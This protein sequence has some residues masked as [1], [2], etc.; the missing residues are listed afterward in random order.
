MPG[1]I[2]RYQVRDKI[3]IGRYCGPRS[4]RYSYEGLI[5]KRRYAHDRGSNSI[6]GFLTAPFGQQSLCTGSYFANRCIVS[7]H[8]EKIRQSSVIVRSDAFENHVKRFD[9]CVQLIEG[10]FATPPAVFRLIVNA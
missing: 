1:E 5:G 2:H 6:A 8:S 3:V 7:D 9:L 10:A 4:G